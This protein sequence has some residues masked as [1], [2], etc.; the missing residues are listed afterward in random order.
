M[1]TSVM[2]GVCSRATDAALCGPCT[3]ALARE[4]RTVPELLTD[5]DLTLARADRIGVGGRGGETPVPWKEHVPDAVWVLGNVL[6]VWVRDT[7]EARGLALV[8][9]PR[10]ARPPRAIPPGARAD[11]E[12][13]PAM[14]TDLP[15]RALDTVRVAAQWLLEHV[16]EL[17]QLAG[18]DDAA[19]G[20]DEITDA[21]AHARRAVDRP[22]VRIFVGPCDDCGDDLYGVPHHVRATCAG[23][24]RLYEDMASRW[25]SALRKLRG[26]PATA[27]TI[28]Q[29]AGELYGVMIDRKLVN[30]WH[31]RGE[32]E[33]VDHVETPE[34]PGRTS[35][36]FRF[37]DVLDRAARSE[38]RPRR[39]AV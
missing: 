17:R 37:G 13:R 34:S 1:T 5:L 36:R 22:A 19:Q 25:E 23:C 3:A 2:C 32:I 14:T 21:I 18:S 10:P 4:L 38:A 39:R 15:N 12:G 16:D 20:W 11:P 30:Q 27:A 8:L 33:P 28:A 29:M 31:S 7:A 6:T 24:G 9:P 35:P 26:Y